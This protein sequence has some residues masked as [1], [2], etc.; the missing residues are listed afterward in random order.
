MTLE[1]SYIVFI[2]LCFICLIKCNPCT[3]ACTNLTCSRKA[4]GREASQ[5]CH[6]H[7]GNGSF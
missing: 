2:S 3:F 1:N 7:A 6:D 4:A 5:N